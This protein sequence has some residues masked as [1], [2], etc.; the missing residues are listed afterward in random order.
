MK[1]FYTTVTT[2]PSADG[3]AWQVMLDKRPLKTVG[4]RAQAVPTQALAA[5]LAG[6]WAAQGDEIDPAAFMLRDMADHAIDVVGPDRAAAV[7]N[8]LR[9][10]ETDT[11]CYRADPDEALH[12]R[13]LEVWEPL[14]AAAEARWDVHFDRISGVIHRPQPAE[15]LKRLEA[16][17]AAQDNFTLAAL[18][19][20]TSLAAS[21][22]IG[23]AA[24]APDAVAATLWAAANLE[25]DWQVELWGQDYE[26]AAL[27]ERRLATFTA[28][29]A[30]ARAARG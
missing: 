23:W 6:E 22:V 5:M 20:L 14:L 24:L 4:G 18:T 30:F 27:R 16:I 17:L 29:M 9:F 28:A 15:T 8:L 11:L 21:L 13:Q 10:A 25:E 12:Q 26:A 1:R 3:S 19:T 2:A 7:Q